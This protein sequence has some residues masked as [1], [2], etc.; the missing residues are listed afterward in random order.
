M[1]LTT[2]EVALGAFLDCIPGQMVLGI[3]LATGGGV[4]VG[5]LATS[6]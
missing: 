3:G 5:L 1:C 2:V 6:R 4:S